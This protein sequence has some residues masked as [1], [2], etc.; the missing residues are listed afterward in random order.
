MSELHPM[1][2]P[3]EPTQSDPFDSVKAGHLLNRA[4]FGGTPQE[5]EHVMKLGPKG[6][7]EELLSFADATAEDQDEDDLPNLSAINDYPPNFRELSRMFIGKSQEERAA[8][9]QKILL[10]NRAALIATGA[11]WMNRMASAKRPLHENRTLFSHDHF[12]TSATPQRG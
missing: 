3:Y 12:T 10:A 6:A 7:V 5:I 8:M 2:K 4:G 11:W 9:F 1:L